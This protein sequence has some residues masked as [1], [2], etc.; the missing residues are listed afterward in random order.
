MTSHY[1]PV[2]NVGEEYL[3]SCSPAKLLQGIHDSYYVSN[4][5]RDLIFAQ[6]DLHMTMQFFVK[7]VCKFGLPVTRT[8]K[9][10]EQVKIVSNVRIWVSNLVE[11]NC[12]SN[13]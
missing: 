3:E 7:P 10:I 6:K 8:I 2:S 4:D 5:D 12:L 11:K 13:Y 9:T 1:K